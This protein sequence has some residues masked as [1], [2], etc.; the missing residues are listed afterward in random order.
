MLREVYTYPERAR[1]VRGH[2][3]LR[4]ARAFADYL[5]LWMKRGDL[6]QSDPL[7]TAHCLFG[8]LW[9]FLLSQELMRGKELHRRSDAPAAARRPTTRA[10]AHAAQ[11]RK[12]TNWSVS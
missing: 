2:V 1:L 7:S 3:N 9:S 4:G 5:S 12:M 11:G 10:G 8:M 6:E